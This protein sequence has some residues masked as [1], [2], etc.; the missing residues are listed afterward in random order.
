[1]IHGTVAHGFESVR[2]GFE[3]GQLSDTGGA[4]LCVYHQG[5]KVVDLWGGKD[6]VRNRPYTDKTIAV[7]MSCTKGAVAICA[8][9]LVQRGLL[10]V[11]APV[12]KYWPEFGQAGKE[13]MPVSDLLAHRSG[14]SSFEPDSGVGVR[15][16]LDWNRCTT[17]LAAMK[18]LWEPGKAAMYHAVTY[19]YLVGEVIRRVSGQMPGVFFAENV[20]KPLGLRFWIGLPEAEEDNVAPHFSSRPAM[21]LEQWK[22]VLDG[23][24]LDTNSRLAAGMMHMLINTD[25]AIQMVNTREGHAAEIP[26]ANGIGDAAS[27]AKMY[28]ATIGEVDGVRLLSKDTMERARKPQTDGLQGPGDFAKL[29]NADPQRMALGFELPRQMEPMLDAGSFGHGGAG[30]RMGFAHPES[31]TAVGYVC[32]NMLWDGISGPDARWL[33][34]TQALK[35]ILKI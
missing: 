19:G 33:P 17:T 30:G 31:G 2:Q 12:T 9:M 28:A 13:K 10:D 32:N 3:E 11:D 4:Q 14:L 22:M 27:L 21:T 8:H 35:D 7:M 23:F 24:G 1:M 6:P 20:A 5:R 16:L 15:E 29:P 26:A 34:W 25:E 18:P